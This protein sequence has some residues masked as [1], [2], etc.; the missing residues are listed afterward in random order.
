MARVGVNIN[1]FIGFVFENPLGFSFILFQQSSNF[2]SSDDILCQQSSNFI[3]CDDCTFSIVSSVR[4]TYDLWL[5]TTDRRRRTI[6][7]TKSRSNFV[8]QW[9]IYLFLIRVPVSVKTNSSFSY[10]YVCKLNL[11]FHCLRSLSQRPTKNFN[12]TT[13]KR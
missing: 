8:R 2:M 1:K 5:F 4:M 7:E 3:S 10:R 9:N 12:V 6:S 13:I 11:I